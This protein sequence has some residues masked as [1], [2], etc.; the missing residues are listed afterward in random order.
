MI[1]KARAAIIT[2][3]K[4]KEAR[5][6]QVIKGLLSML[7]S[8]FIGNLTRIGLVFLLSRYYSK[9]EFGVW[10]VITSTA[11]VIAYG[12]F[13]IIN[14]LRN[15]LS[16]LL[17]KGEM[18]LKDAKSYF[19]TAFISFSFISIILSLFFIV[20]SKFIAF[21]GLF[22]TESL[23]LKE[24]G[25]YIILWVQFLFFINIPLSMGVAC[26]F[27]FHE[28]KF[29][30]Y[31]STAQ[32]IISFFVVLVL[33]FFKASM[34]TISIAYFGVNTLISAVGTYYFLKRRKWFSYRFEY[35]PFVKQLKE[36][37][38][39]GIKF[40]GYQLSNSFLQN[41]GTLLASAYLGVGV[42]AE[43]NMVQK[44]Y[45]FAIGIYQSIFNPIWGGYAEA[46]AKQDWAWCKRTLNISLLATAGIF[47]TACIVLYF[48][49]N[50]FLMLLAGEAY[51]ANKSL[52]LLIGLTSLFFILFSAATVI[53]NA[54]NKINLLLIGTV[55]LSFA[56]FPLSKILIHKFDVV[57]I[58]IA[59]SGTWLLLFILLTYQAYHIIN[60]NIKRSSNQ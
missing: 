34:L 3:F 6:K 33:V 2:I 46:A 19:Y 58:A 24:N 12:D 10:A 39:T 52:F 21:D 28:A 59:T 36:L 25:V 32:T 29:S 9:E 13:G 37:C 1:K 42:A 16:E 22:K 50:T 45:S 49:G 17:V 51:V 4:V 47:I 30:A 5:T 23:F 26:F 41:A 8:S 18:G 55:V 38:G 31:V 35:G 15:K 53:Q 7:V 56:I 11:A 60:T 43:Y 44:L 40:M 48:F 14:A 54:L 27:S 57:G 20:L